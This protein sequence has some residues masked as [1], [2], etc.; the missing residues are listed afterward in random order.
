MTTDRDIY[1]TPRRDDTVFPQ[2]HVTG[3]VHTDVVS[4]FL[5]TRSVAF[6][7]PGPGKRREIMFQI[8]ANP[9]T[10]APITMQMS[11]FSS[12]VHPPR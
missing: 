7:R 5:Q 12:P 3:Q 9:Q 2:I 11:S 4:E 6:Y 10:L 1:Y 8:A